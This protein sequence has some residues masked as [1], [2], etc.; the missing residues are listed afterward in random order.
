MCWKRDGEGLL[1]VSSW[2]GSVE[3]AV[4][5]P[6]VTYLW[7][8]HIDSALRRANAILPGLPAG[9]TTRPWDPSPRSDRPFAHGIPTAAFPQTSRSF[10]GRLRSA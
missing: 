7:I 6:H 3:R 5:L 4:L 1:D 10:R 8:D 9:C 2:T